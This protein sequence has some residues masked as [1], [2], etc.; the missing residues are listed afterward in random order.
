MSNGSWD[1]DTPG[2]LPYMDLSDSDVR[3]LA[4]MNQRVYKC[5]RSGRWVKGPRYLI[6]EPGTGLP[7]LPENSNG[8]RSIPGYDEDSLG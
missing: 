8:T 2:A 7:V 6:R 1:L 4:T 3:T 5:Y